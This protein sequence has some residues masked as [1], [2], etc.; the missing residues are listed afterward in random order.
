[1]AKTLKCE[2]KVFLCKWKNYKKNIIC[3]KINDS[4]PFCGMIYSEF[5]MELI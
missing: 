5:M 4:K 3:A 2:Y 1:M